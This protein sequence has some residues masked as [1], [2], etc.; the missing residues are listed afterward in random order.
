MV[1]LI[2]NYLKLFD[3]VLILRYSGMLLHL[4]RHVAGHSLA[5]I[6][7]HLALADKHFPSEK[8][9]VEFG[10][11]ELS[12]K[13]LNRS[14]SGLTTGRTLKRFIWRVPRK[15]RGASGLVALIRAIIRE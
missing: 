14:C 8:E 10:I 5:L 12:V 11:G 2:Y 4:M 1:G 15:Q 6:N 9:L 3:R 13:R 7:E